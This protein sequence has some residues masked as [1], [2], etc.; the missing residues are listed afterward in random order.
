MGRLCY[1]QERQVIKDT[2]M[3]VAAVVDRDTYKALIDK[4]KGVP[5]S[6]WVRDKIAEEL[7]TGGALSNE[8]DRPASK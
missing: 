5:F 7:A 3:R 6:A 2:N 4:L 1:Y 8:S